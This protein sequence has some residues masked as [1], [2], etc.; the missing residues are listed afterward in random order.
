MSGEDWVDV[1]L[2]AFGERYL[3][4]NGGGPL[5]VHD[6]NREFDF[7]SGETK[8]VTRAYDWHQVL[9]L[10]HVNGMAL[11]QV[12]PAGRVI[13]PQKSG[14]APGPDDPRSATLPK[15]KN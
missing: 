8:R 9:R 4:E 13:I 2:T 1:Q 12:A 7:A 14:G 11:F 6:G 15:E 10:Q 3:K 5:R